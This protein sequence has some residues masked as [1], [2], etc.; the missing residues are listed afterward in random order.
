M[1]RFMT[2]RL[3]KFTTPEGVVSKKNIRFKPSISDLKHK[4]KGGVEGLSLRVSTRPTEL[5]VYF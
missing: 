2:L 3:E 1:N 4:E 5:S